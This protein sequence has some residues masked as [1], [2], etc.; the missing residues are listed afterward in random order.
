[1]TR[2]YIITCDAI[3]FF[4]LG[5]GGATIELREGAWFQASLITAKIQ[6]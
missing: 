3:L 4:F 1:M 5:G 2:F 6:F